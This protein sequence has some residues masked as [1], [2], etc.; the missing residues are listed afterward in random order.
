[1]FR[2]AIKISKEFT[3]FQTN[4]QNEQTI[5]AKNH[6]AVINQIQS[7][8]Y[9]QTMAGQQQQQ[10]L[11]PEQHVEHR[12]HRVLSH[13]PTEV[14][15]FSTTFILFAVGLSCLVVSGLEYANASSLDEAVNCG[16][17]GR[18]PLLQ[19]VF[20]TG[21]AYLIIWF[22]YTINSNCSNCAVDAVGTFPK[23]VVSL[24]NT[25]LLSWSI[26]GGFSLWRHGRDCQQSN[27][28]LFRMGYSAVIISII[29]VCCGGYE[30]YESTVIHT[31]TARTGGDVENQ[32]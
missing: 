2:F 27:I 20:G 12:V 26:V 29:L 21:I 32:K 22:A 23:W 18:P 24:S 5:D 25:F 16:F 7:I 17:N 28:T 4:T 30:I 14:C 8:D 6:K 11:Q 19:W 31:T 10:Q 1:M 15:C 3:A 9:L 13:G